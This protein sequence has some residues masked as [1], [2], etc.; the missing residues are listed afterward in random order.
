MYRKCFVILVA[1]A[2]LLVSVTPVAAITHGQKD[3]DAHPYVGVALL[4]DEDNG[5][6]GFCSGTL[7][8]PT[9]FLTAGHCTFVAAYATVSFDPDFTDDEEFP[10]ILG[11]PYTHPG[12]DDFATFP[13]TRDVGIVLLQEAV[14]MD[15][16][17]ELPELGALDALATGRSRKE[18]LFTTVGYGYQSVVPKWMWEQVRYNSTSML[19]NLK[20]ALTDGYN[21][22]TSNNPGKGQG[23]GG[24]CFGDSGGPVLLGDSNMVVGIVSFGLNRNCVGADFAYRTDIPDAQDFIKGFLE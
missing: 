1:I 2:L 22:H 23:T 18:T 9:V 17:A 7:L 6:L 8:S 21:L 3:G 13:N 19:V 11:S 15:T 14:E 10:W 24:S 20:S 5:L 4:F 12:F 16:Y